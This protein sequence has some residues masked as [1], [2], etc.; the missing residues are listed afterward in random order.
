MTLKDMKVLAIYLVPMIA[1]YLFDLYVLEPGRMTT[2]AEMRAPQMN[3]NAISLCRR[4]FN[5]LNLR[6]RDLD[7]PLIHSRLRKNSTEFFISWNTKFSTK[8]LCKV[9]TY[10]NRYNITQYDYDGDN[11]LPHLVEE[12]TN[13]F[14]VNWITHEPFN[15]NTDEE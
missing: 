12:K 14:D 9:E 6:N 8:I 2:R 10:Q 1:I 11:I 13:F 3:E 7:D 5:V 15:K 4:G